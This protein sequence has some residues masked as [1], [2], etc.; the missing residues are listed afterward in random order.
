MGLNA[1][2]L[3]TILCGPLIGQ[4]AVTFIGE[5]LQAIVATL[6]LAGTL[7]FV[8]RPLRTTAIV[9]ASVLACLWSGL[10]TYVH[11][12]FLLRSIP[13]YAYGALA[14]FLTGAILIRGRGQLHCREERITG[15]TCAAW[16]LH[17]LTYPLL[18]PVAWL[19]PIGFMVAEGLLMMIAVGLIFIAFRRMQDEPRRVSA[20]IEQR[21]HEQLALN[22]ILRIALDELPL[23]E[24]LDRC[25]ATILA[26]PSLGLL[27]KGGIFIAEE[28]GGPLS[29]AAQ[30][31]LPETMQSPAESLG[32][33]DCLCGAVPPASKTRHGHHNV[34]ILSGEERL[35]VIALY[36]PEGESPAGRQVLF[37][38]SVAN[39]LAGMIMRRRSEDSMVSSAA[40]F[41]ALIE[42]AQD[43]IAILDERGVIRYHSPG[44]RRVLGY[45]PDELVGTQGLDLVHPDDRDHVRSCFAKVLSSPGA[46]LLLSYRYRRKG[47][48]WI[49]LESTFKNMIDDPIVE[50][51]VLNSRDITD[52]LRTE[53]MLRQSQKLEAVGQLSGGIAHDF[54]NIIG[55]VMGNLEILQDR[56][57][58]DPEASSLVERAIGGAQRGAQLTKKLLG[59]SRRRAQRTS[60]TS[61]NRVVERIDELVAKSLTASIQVET[62]LA[63]DLWPVR[64][65][66]GDLEDAIVNLAINARD[67]MPQGGVLTIETANRVQEGGALTGIGGGFPCDFV[68]L[69]VGDT[70]TGMPEDVAA[71]AIEPFFT[72]KE[73]G[74]GTGLGLSMVY[75]LAIRSG[76]SF[77]IESNVGKGTTCRLYL[78]RA[79]VPEGA[80]L[81]DQPARPAASPGGTESILVVDDEAGLLDVTAQHLEG[82]GYRVHRAASAEEALRALTRQPDIDLLFSDV[83]MPGERDGY[84]LAEACR[85]VRPELKVLLTSGFGTPRDGT[86]D[87]IDGRLAAQ[88]AAFL[89]KPYSRAGL[90]GAVR[91]TLDGE[92]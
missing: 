24:Q 8:G 7:I 62:R 79:E 63:A 85:A 75:G 12:D 51:V 21:H 22:D 65:D 1:V 25:L 17:K 59:F 38:E 27:P 81:P 71:Q 37:L 23:K 45:D 61:I 35:G 26:V 66:P 4:P 72:T 68:M 14:L 30:R 44:G 6:L 73:P 33:G 80:S 52:R 84:Q 9:G 40:R 39:T 86:A 89:S 31:G 18:H 67:A 16:G 82:L 41:R 91:K 60:V 54:N 74:R 64:I 19:A 48:H 77:T 55:I 11:P 57:A 90:A 32:V 34:P 83:V 70:G 43:T 42:N 15:L 47:G 28:Q 53:E 87:D 69:S 10:T 92:A 2:R 3:A 13:L 36:L 20:E 56:V 58:G 46:P 88:S 76:G 29:L 50:G 49:M 5:S 78:P